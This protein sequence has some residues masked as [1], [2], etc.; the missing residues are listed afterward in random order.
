MLA[1]RKRVNRKAARRQQMVVNAHH[2]GTGRFPMSL[3]AA[4]AGEVIE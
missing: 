4:R 2:L 1:A 3:P